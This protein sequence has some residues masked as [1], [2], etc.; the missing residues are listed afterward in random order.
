[1]CNGTFCDER[2]TLYWFLWQSL[3]L[4][5]SAY[6]T[7]EMRLVFRGTEFLFSSL[8]RIWRLTVNSD[9]WNV[10]C[11]SKEPSASYPNDRHLVLGATSFGNFWDALR[12]SNISTRYGYWQKMSI[13]FNM[14]SHDKKG[15]E[16]IYL[17]RPCHPV[18]LFII[19]FLDSTW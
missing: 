1:M 14:H 15:P 6:K 16:I 18:H 9:Y 3:V 4:V 11:S 8:I 19:S 12:T 13:T 5:L 7:L 2:N 10:N 17:K